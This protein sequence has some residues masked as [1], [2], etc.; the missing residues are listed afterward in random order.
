MKDVAGT[1]R[2]EALPPGGMCQYK[3][4]VTQA[5]EV[6]KELIGWVRRAYDS[7]G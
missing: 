5:R 3:V 6:D 1:S 7:A 4:K 2:L